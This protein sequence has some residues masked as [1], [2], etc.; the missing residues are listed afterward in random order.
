MC[1]GDT[2]GHCGALALMNFRLRL[3]RI[4]HLGIN[5]YSIF[6]KSR[7]NVNWN[8]LDSPSADLVDRSFKYAIEGRGASL[9]Q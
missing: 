9:H 8:W 6:K 3:E 1:Y 4:N 7:L 5:L 2:C